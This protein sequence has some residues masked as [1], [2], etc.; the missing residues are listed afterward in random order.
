METLIRIL[1]GIPG[2]VLLCLGADWL[3]KG[4]SGAARRLGV[5]SLV[6]GLTL[7]AFGTSAPELVVSVD[8]ALKGCGGLSMGNVVGSNICNVALILGA[9][10]LVTPVKV[11]RR[12]YRL[13]FP[14]LIVASLAVAAC[15]W[16]NGGVTRWQG[17]LFF[18]ACVGYLVW[19]GVS[20]HAAG[21]EE[22]K[23]GTKPMGLWAALGLACVGMAGLAVG[24]RLLV[25]SAVETAR[26]LGVS[27]AVI[28]LTVVALGTSLPELATSLMA[29]RKRECDI[30]MGNVVGSNLFNILGILGV[31][32]LIRP[33]EGAGLHAA[34]LAVMTG[35]AVLLPVMGLRRGT[36]GRGW[37][38][39]LCLIYVGYCGWLVVRGG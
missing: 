22:E 32:P 8:A 3:V 11:N 23:E 37:G 24:A 7:V 5:P 28:G 27:D 21:A 14:L 38:G 19:T 16:H 1:A 25:D 17:G 10:A 18:A 31:T 39:V 12:L 13:D 2:L 29:A 36:V 34:D 26:L 35:L 9:A 33:I 20:G 4:G 15:F 6:I 30:A